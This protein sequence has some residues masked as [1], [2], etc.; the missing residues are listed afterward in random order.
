QKRDLREHSRLQIVIVVLL[1]EFEAGI[2]LP[3]F[4]ERKHVEKLQCWGA[5]EPKPKV[6][7]LP[8]DML[9]VQ[10]IHNGWPIQVPRL[11]FMYSN[12]TRGGCPEIQP[13]WE[14]WTELRP[15]VIA[16]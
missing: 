16:T 3:A 2:T 7:T 12:P 14:S 4:E 6:V 9:G 8:A 1:F 5:S 15:K 11:Y 10:Q 13:I